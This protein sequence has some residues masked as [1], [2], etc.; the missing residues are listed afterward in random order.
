MQ[1]LLARLLLLLQFPLDSELASTV[2]IVRENIA[3]IILYSHTSDTSVYV[4]AGSAAN[5]QFRIAKQT[6]ETI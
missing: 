4:Q 5:L 1:E 6:C 3:Q 2:L